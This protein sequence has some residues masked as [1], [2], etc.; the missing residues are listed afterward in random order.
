ME[1]RLSPRYDHEKLENP[2]LA[3]LIDVF[4]DSWKSFVFSPA[5][6]LLTHPDGDVAAM[7][8]ITSY[9][10]AIWIYRT[11]KDSDGRSREYFTNGFNL[12]FSSDS[13]GIDIAAKA[14]YK[15]IRCGLAHT[16][17]LT[18]KV[19]FSRVGKKTFFLTYPKNQDGSLNMSAPVAGIFVNPMRMYDGVTR[20]FRVYVAALR[21]GERQDL[22]NPFQLAAAQLWGLG[23]GGNIIGMSEAEFIGHA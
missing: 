9:F 3:D 2:T 6:K 21:S 5:E 22:T 23:K 20:H 16:G 18:H 19:N 14:I 4:E 11:G 8:L 7:T 17:M 10:E 15:H 1:Y 13:P 12:V